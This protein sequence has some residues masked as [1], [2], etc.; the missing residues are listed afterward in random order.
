VLGD[1]KLSRLTTPALERCKAELLQTRSRAMAR[2]V[3]GSLKMMIGE[4][5]RQGYIAQNV[6]APVKVDGRGRDRDRIAIPSKAEVNAII[7]AAEG[8]W[9]PLLVARSSP[10][11]A[12]LSFRGLR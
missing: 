5:M 1:Q 8:R 12:P 7:N 10:G 6:A 9:R 3:L 2:K 4:A 11:C